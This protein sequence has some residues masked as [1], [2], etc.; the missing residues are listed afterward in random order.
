MELTASVKPYR[1]TIDLIAFFSHLIF[2]HSFAN[3]RYHKTKIL[4]IDKAATL[5]DFYSRSV[6]QF[7]FFEFKYGKISSFSS[8]G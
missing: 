8:S 4:A 2:N 6:L 7:K 3:L 5:N 1:Y